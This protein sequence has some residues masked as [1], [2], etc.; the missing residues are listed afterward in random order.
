MRLESRNQAHELANE[1]IMSTEDLNEWVAHVQRHTREREISSDCAICHDKGPDHWTYDLDYNPQLCSH[2]Q[3]WNDARHT[4]SCMGSVLG[5]NYRGPP[6]TTL[7]TIISNKHCILCQCIYDAITERCGRN[8]ADESPEMQV[9]I[10]NPY[11]YS[12]TLR[13]PNEIKYSTASPTV[14][15]CV[16]FTIVAENAKEVLEEMR[17]RVLRSEFTG[18]WS[19]A[20][21][22]VQVTLHYAGFARHLHKV[23]R[24]DNHHFPPNVI[25]S[26]LQQCENNHHACRLA[27]PRALPTGMMLIDTQRKCIVSAPADAQYLALSYAWRA[28]PYSQFHQLKVGTMDD[29]H[30]AGSL[31]RNDVPQLVWD[32]ITLCHDLGERYLWVDRLCIVQDD[33]KVMRSQIMA[34]DVIY[35]AAHL[36]IVAAANDAGEHPGLPGVTGHP[37]ASSVHDRARNFQIDPTFV[38]ENL[39]LAIFRS[40][41]NSRA[42]TFQERLLSRRILMLTEHQ[43]YLFCCQSAHQEDIGVIDHAAPVIRK[44][45]R[46]EITTITNVVTLGDYFD[47][48]DEYTSRDLSFDSDILDAFAG[49]TNYMSHQ[50]ETAFLFGL[51]ERYLIR[52]MLWGPQDY[53]VSRP[54]DAGFAIPT[55]SWAAWCGGVQYTTVLGNYN[56]A[57][58]VGH[59]AE[60]YG[61]LVRMF[62]FDSTKTLR[63]MGIE[64]RWFQ[65]STPFTELENTPLPNTKTAVAKY[66]AQSPTEVWQTCPQNPWSVFS[67]TVFEQP[68]LD[69]ARALDGALVFNT[70]IASLTLRHRTRYTDRS[71]L[72]ICDPEGYSVGRMQRMTNEWRAAHMSLSK[73]HHFIVLCA[74]VLPK[75]E[76]RG[77]LRDKDLW[78]TEGYMDHLW[79]QEL[80]AADPV[81]RRFK[82]SERDPWLLRLMMVEE[83]AFELGVFRRLGIG[84]VETRCWHVCQPIW[85]T[86]VLV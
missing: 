79:K 83:D 86:I 27:A 57:E 25:R 49:I 42:W 5:W 26:W 32:A 55:W 76:K 62:T 69:C 29:L 12:Q 70:T 68:A 28:I 34:M 16:V 54:R 13:H 3:T 23:E 84:F 45:S 31:S 8:I 52:S 33:V 36:T 38:R 78:D 81:N 24:W 65:E 73:S 35:S 48:V 63:R 4:F 43:A 72:D 61:T 77:P 30:E 9:L 75:I 58:D 67:Q 80:L 17:D 19:E 85:R 1:E 74:G 2:C 60:D 64:E 51:P 59:N 7:A 44:A 10:G 20:C 22:G 41:W 15:R 11:H 66:W 46:K 40:R 14:V 71:V 18:L 39:N 37:R 6:P 47:C 50:F 21:M 56:W 82:V 53:N